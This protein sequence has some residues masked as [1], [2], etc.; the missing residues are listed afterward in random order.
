MD[1]NSDNKNP[2]VIFITGGARSG[3]SSLALSKAE[4]ISG[5]KLFVATAEPL[6]EEMKTRI[7][8]HRQERGQG[9]DT[10]EEPLAIWDTLK[11]MGA[12][13]QVILIDC[14]TLWLSN[15]LGR[16]TAGVDMQTGAKEAINTFVNDLEAIKRSAHRFDDLAS[17]I[18]VSNELGMGIV[19]DN[20]L[21]RIFRDKAGRLNQE[22]AGIADEVYLV[23]S[24]IPLRLKG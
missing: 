12:P 21:A 20:R 1:I 5:K 19:P 4:K 13:Y 6:D 17:I 8:K 7:E 3:K 16:Q 23:V 10:L 9:W 15:V 18:I 2:A 24:G 14:L 22:I 11:R